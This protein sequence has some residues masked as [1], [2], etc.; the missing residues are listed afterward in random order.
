MRV[1][2]TVLLLVALLPGIASALG[3]G[4]LQL[5]SALNEP[6]SARIDLISASVDE[7]DSMRVVLAD[8]EAFKRAGIQRPAILTELQ[9]TVKQPESG[10]DYIRIYTND[11]VR[12][13]FLNFL[14]EVSWSKGRLFREYTVLLDPPIYANAEARRKLSQKTETAP[15]TTG[16]IVREI[17]D[18]NVV[19]NPEYKPAQKTRTVSTPQPRTINYTGGDYGPVVQGDTLWSL[20]REMR[21]DSSVSIQQMMLALL[22]TNPEAFI[23]NNINGLKR[24]H[25]LKMPDLSEVQSVNKTDAFAEAKL[26]NELWDEARGALATRVT[27]RPESTT[28]Q[29]VAPVEAPAA[30][31]AAPA[32][33]TTM[34][35]EAESPELRL[36][37]PVDEGAAGE[38]E[39][40]QE[41]EALTQE[42]ALANESLEALKLE[43]AELRDKLSETE[44]IIDDL[45]RLIVLKESELAE[46][47]QQI[48]NAELE[49]SQQEMQEPMVAETTEP[50]EPVA[51]EPAAEEAMEEEPAAE[52][53]MEAEAGAEEEFEDIDAATATEETSWT[54][55]IPDSI[56]GIVSNLRN[57]LPY[58]GAAVGALILLIV[59]SLYARRRKSQPA[60]EIPQSEF[61]EFAESDQE[62]FSEDATDINP[63]IEDIEDETI[64]KDADET[65][66]PEFVEEEPQLPDVPSEQAAPEA[67]ADEEEDPMAEVNVFLAYE[68]F[69]Q[70]EEFVKGAI[71]K[72]PDNLEFHTKLLEVYYAA[73][74][75]KG[76]EEEARVLHEMV[77]GE[78]DYWNMAVAMWQ[79][80]SPNREL[81]AEPVAGEEE[82]APAPAEEGGGI[83]NIAGDG[84]STTTGLDLDL[85][86]SAG[87]EE[88]MEPEE[89]E[90]SGD[91]DILDVTSAIDIDE[92]ED[93]LDVTSSFD[94][95]K[96]DAKQ[97]TDEEVDILDVSAA[98]NDDA[99]DISLDSAEDETIDKSVDEALDI[100]LGGETGETQDAGA[101][102]D[103]SLDFSF[104]M[105]PEGESEGDAAAEAETVVPVDEEESMDI[106][107]EDSQAGGEGG[108]DAGDALDFSLD[109]DEDSGADEGGAETEA[110]SVADDLD[111]SLDMEES[112]PE[113]S[114]ESILDVSAGL[115]MEEEESISE[116][117][118]SGDL[119]D[120]SQQSDGDLLD[121]TKSTN[122]EL[123]GEEDLLDVTTSATSAG[124]DAEELLNEEGQDSADDSVLDISMESADS[125]DNASEEG[126]L[127]F[128]L[129]PDNGDAADDTGLEFSGLD[130]GNET[131]ASDDL[132]LD[133]DIG[134]S[135]VSAEESDGLPDMDA[136][137]QMPKR[138]N[139][140]KDEAEEE[141]D[142]TMKMPKQGSEPA[143]SK[144]ELDLEFIM[145]EDDDES[146]K[147]IMVPKSKD[148][149][150]QSADDEIATQL[151]LAKAY[152][153]LGDTENAKTILNEIL[154]AGNESQRKQAE[155]LLG[156]I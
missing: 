70:A 20:A 98:R 88:A 61:P 62:D 29:E 131:A 55:Y 63:D 15:S 89:I 26:Q 44:G 123:D 53:P 99:L 126:G 110:E 19:Y 42:L 108:V 118:V 41:T 103:N 149:A 1:I 105:E 24:G 121:V 39:G 100:S 155:E 69:D 17:E 93:L 148:S 58:L 154:E 75:K 90:D 6:F 133:L 82:E 47:Q 147:T 130:D 136:T 119:L 115:G 156:Q 12:E 132:G 144:E 135:D 92:D 51:E 116:E 83:L 86:T 80:I 104:D 21:P 46:L 2:Q 43:N 111:F 57:N 30:E 56:A 16:E 38:Q 78:G 137:M 127:D 32:P 74:N 138:G 139:L 85:D 52:E 49:A 13:P 102:D 23:N 65:I 84:E 3:L 27:P 101:A 28:A 143:A 8:P 122:I 4:K 79:E 68:H 73:N 10:A 145:E 14:I 59:G 60:V 7:L 142:A 120:V 31:P 18:N 95:S 151:D 117:S 54:S 146:D 97:D 125:E 50:A 45:Q 71:E 124:M 94:D 33:E 37:A 66:A 134:A 141:M 34:V 129:S 64:V 77:N 112:K 72:D 114:D 109:L 107:L 76:Y 96:S 150:E 5:Q 153:E 9:F 106:P 113:Q 91:G 140:E 87:H 11:P 22:R 128:E 25:V 36:V 67:A 81:F 35:E 152:V 48:A 40:A